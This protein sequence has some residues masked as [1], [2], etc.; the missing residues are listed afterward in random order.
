MP[1]ATLPDSVTYTISKTAGGWLL[2]IENPHCSLSQVFQS[3][4]SARHAV[5]RTALALESLT[6]QHLEMQR[7]RERN[8]LP[9]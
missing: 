9:F 6:A 7:A 1:S 4:S 3:S 5:A 8:Q 2:V